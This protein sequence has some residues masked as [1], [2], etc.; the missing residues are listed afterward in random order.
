MPR[1][2]NFEEVDTDDFVGGVQTFDDY[3]I[4]QIGMMD[5]DAAT[6]HAARAIVGSLDRDGFFCVKLS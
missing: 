6:M 2:P 3:L 1:D 4:Q 5:L